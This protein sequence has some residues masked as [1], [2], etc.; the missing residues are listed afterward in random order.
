MINVVDA[1]GPERLLDIENKVKNEFKNP[2]KQIGPKTYES[3]L[4]EIDEMFPE[5]T[6]GRTFKGRF[7][8]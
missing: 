1:D 4:A 3:F 2:T 5:Q 8:R 6:K 7:Q